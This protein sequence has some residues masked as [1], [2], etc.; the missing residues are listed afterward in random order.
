MKPFPNLP[1]VV[2]NRLPGMRDG[3]F[4]NIQAVFIQEVGGG[5]GLKQKAEKLTRRIGQNLRF[6]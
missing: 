4:F 1:G 6:I 2:L 3:V 5:G